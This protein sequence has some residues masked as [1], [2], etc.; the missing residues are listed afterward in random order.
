MKYFT[1]SSLDSSLE[2]TYQKEIF[3]TSNE[4]TDPILYFGKLNSSFFP[5]S[6]PNFRFVRFC[7]FYYN[8]FNGMSNFLYSF[9]KEKIIPLLEHSSSIEFCLPYNFLDRTDMF[10]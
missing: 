9:T 10:L 1:L 4:K 2:E 6:Y 3:P 5:N 7:S 8:T